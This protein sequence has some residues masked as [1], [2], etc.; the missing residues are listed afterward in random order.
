MNGLQ[1]AQKL[2]PK[3]NFTKAIQ[4][5]LLN[6]DYQ[7]LFSTCDYLHL[8][9]GHDFNDYKLKA[10]EKKLQSRFELFRES[11]QSLCIFQLKII[12]V[13]LWTAKNALVS[14]TETN[15]EAIIIKGL[16]YQ[17][18]NPNIPFEEVFESIPSVVFHSLNREAVKPILVHSGELEMSEQVS[19]VKSVF[20]ALLISL[21]PNVINFLKFFVQSQLLF[22]LALFSEK[23]RKLENGIPEALLFTNFQT[24]FK[25]F[26]VLDTQS[27]F[28]NLDLFYYAT[29][30]NINV[31]T[32]LVHYSESGMPLLSSQDFFNEVIPGYERAEVD[33]HIV[34][35]KEFANFY[36]SRSSTPNFIAL[37][38]QVFRERVMEKKREISDE[39]VLAVF[40][41]TP[42]FHDEF[43]THIREEAGLNF[44]A[45][46]EC[47]SKE[48]NAKNGKKLK[49]HLKQKRRNLKFHSRQ[50]LEKLE[51]MNSKGQIKLLPW[52]TNPYLMISSSDL[53]LS[54]LGSSPALIGRYLS[55]PTV[56]GYF[57]DGTIA[58]PII[59]YGIP[60]LRNTNQLLIWIHN[61][62]QSQ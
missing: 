13:F 36:N 9:T 6:R 34:W 46:I 25:Y 45:A 23:M 53:V 3:I 20:F 8:P 35:T 10:D 38:P 32:Y 7:S 37:G 26:S 57:G 2:I 1:I 21:K 61:Y 31:R 52:H 59:D 5:E 29:N 24:R 55:R 58:P 27:S 49:I 14:P 11:V 43:Y 44:L 22:I 19:Q 56:Y 50:Y 15:N 28:L 12:R 17:Q 16:G 60:V 33:I 39:I 51:E 30:Q 18:L 48:F 47:L 54:V 40:D 4:D 62:S 41:E 42:S